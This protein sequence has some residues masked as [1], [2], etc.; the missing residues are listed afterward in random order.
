MAASEDIQPLTAAERRWGLAAVIGCVTVFGLSIGEGV[1]LLSLL[2]EG[3]GTDAV[4]TGLNAGSAFIGVILGPLLAPRGVRLFGLRGLLLACLALDIAGF[5]LMRVFDSLAAWFALRILLGLIGSSIFTASEAWINLLAGASGHDAARGRIIGVYAAA[6]S[7]G[8]GL[9]PLLLWV[10]GTEGWAPF[11]ANAVI[12]A[13]AALPLLGVGNAAAGFGRERGASPLAMFLRAPFL[14]FTVAVF[15]LYETSLLTLLPIWG[16]REGLAAGA[17]ASVV[18]AVYFGAIAAQVPVGWLS[19]KVGRRAALLLCG[20]VG[21]AGAALVPVAAGSPP[22]LFC[23]LFV[24][25]GVAGGIYPVALGMAGDRFRNGELVAVNAA[26]VMAYGLGSLAGPTVGGAAMDAW[27]PQGLLG[28]FVVLFACFL[29]VTVWVQGGP[30]GRLRPL[31][32]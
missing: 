18:S 11:I 7:A 21:M 22:V 19:D 10:T 14:V 2:L 12:T 23:V 29:A 13:A 27:N 25:G 26:I 17:A 3:R 32:P 24:W 5:M 1:P 20:A 30:P 8:F 6:L 15:G 4:L 9:G 31:V 28:F 16:V